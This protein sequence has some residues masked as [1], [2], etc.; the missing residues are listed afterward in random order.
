LIIR[1][2]YDVIGE[3][4]AETVANHLME[5]RMGVVGF[6]EGGKCGEICIGGRAVIYV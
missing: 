3:E 5:E 6:Q 1:I 4:I 2:F